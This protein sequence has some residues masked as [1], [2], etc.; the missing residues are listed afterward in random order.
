M[1]TEK[2]KVRV[3][4][5]QFPLES[6]SRGV[7]TVIGMLRDAGM[8]VIYLG[9]SLPERI[10]DSALQEDVDVVGIS[11]L[12]GG[13]LVLGGKVM[14]LAEEKG[15]KEGVAFLMGGIFPPEDEPKLREMGFDGL[16]PPGS[17]KEEI[18]KCILETVAAKRNS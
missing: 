17:T 4:V 7:F 9:N 18:T 8:E 3:L 16:F 15:V 6:H 11:T 2:D 1:T 13:E 10:V 5:A 12:T 14:R